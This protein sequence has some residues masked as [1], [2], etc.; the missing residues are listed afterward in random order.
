MIRCMNISLE[1]KRTELY[2]KERAKNSRMD[3]KMK[4]EFIRLNDCK[5]ININGLKDILKMVIL[6]SFQTYD[7]RRHS[8]SVSQR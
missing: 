7:P 3:S 5:T 2:L 6:S 8:L 1:K 4:Q